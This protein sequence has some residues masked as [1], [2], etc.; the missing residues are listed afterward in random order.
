[1]PAAW[2]E[3]AVTLTSIYNT[4]QTKKSSGGGGDAGAAIWQA[5]QDAALAQ[6]Q[7]AYNNPDRYSNVGSETRVK[8]PA[9]KAKPA[10]KY[11]PAK[12]DKNGVMIRPERLA[13]PAVKAKAAS[14]KTETNLRSELKNTQDL[15]LKKQEELMKQA[16]A[17]GAFTT[18][19]QI[20]FDQ[21]GYKKYGD[22]IYANAMS[23]VKPEQE[24]DL[25]A[26]HT[27]LRQQ[28]LQP[29]DAAYDRAMK[30][31]MTAQGDVQA[32]AAL[33]A[34]TAGQDA[35]LKDASQ[36]SLMRNTN[37][38]ED[39]QAWEDPL[40]R[41]QAYG[42]AASQ[43][44]SQLKAS[45]PGYGTAAAAQSG[46]DYVGLQAAKNQSDAA[47]KAAQA[48]A[49]GTAIAGI[50]KAAGNYFANKT[51]SNYGQGS[52]GMVYDMGR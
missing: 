41:A 39:R 37:V 34:R 48:Q 36:S 45:L 40:N 5:Q 38:A 1:M 10:V 21:E 31:L 24:H 42:T 17:Q 43:P 49:Y 16:A 23:R 27:R 30:N 20:E 25:A 50:G 29:G 12:Y 28:G 33:Q 13:Q 2:V 19:P 35:Y 47:A 32:Q 46:V 14:W 11:R 9:V 52:D 8:I 26:M 7:N 44:D 51:P 22:D 18:D 4:T 15:G 6:Q 3:G